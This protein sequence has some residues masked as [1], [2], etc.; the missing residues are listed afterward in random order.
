MS[1]LRSPLLLSSRLRSP[2]LHSPIFSL[3]KR[4][5]LFMYRCTHNIAMSCPSL[6]VDPDSPWDVNYPIA[7]NRT[8]SAISRDEIVTMLQ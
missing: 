4:D 5:P 1:W 7:K 8:P 3:S 6:P 2:W